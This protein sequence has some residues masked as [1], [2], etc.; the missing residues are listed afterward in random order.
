M[1]RDAQIASLLAQLRPGLD[2]RD[3]PSEDAKDALVAALGLVLTD[4]GRIADAVERL[5]LRGDA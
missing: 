1:T 3:A 5:A 2:V 4:L